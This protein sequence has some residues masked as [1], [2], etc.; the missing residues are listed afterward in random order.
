[1]EVT[2]RSCLL[3]QGPMSL[4]GEYCQAD[5]TQLFQASLAIWKRSFIPI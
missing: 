3:L 5:F 1:M 2:F 4:D